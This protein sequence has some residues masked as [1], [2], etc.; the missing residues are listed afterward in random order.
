MKLTIKQ[1]KFAD[2]YIITGNATEAARKA[3]YSVKTANRIATE[4]LSKPVI[5]EYIDKRL[6]ELDD[7]AIMKQEEIMKLLS[8][9]G[10]RQEMESVV[11]TVTQE[12]SE[13]IDGKK[14]TVKEEIPKIVQIPAKL[15]DANRALELLGK[16]YAMWTD[17]IDS[18]GNMM[19]VFEDDYG[20]TDDS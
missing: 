5:Q 12:R 10:R 15:S 11:V 19:I 17:K 4:N 3:G 8:R 2:E 6:Q 18:A 9:T 20:D 14:M 7:E 13:W 1:K 16:R